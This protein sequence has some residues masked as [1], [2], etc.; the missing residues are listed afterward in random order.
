MT[1]LVGL[2]LGADEPTRTVDA[3]GLVF[4]APA[5]WKPVTVTNPMRKAQLK[6]EPAKGDERG[7]ELIVSTFAGTA[8]G[9]DAN[10]GRWE[11]T[12][13]DKDGNPVKAEVKKVKGKNVDVTRVELAGHYYPA[14]FGGP[15][16]PD[17]PNTR[18]LGAIV[19]TD[20]T[21]YFVRFIGPE[22]TISDAKADFDK[23]I[24]SMKAEGK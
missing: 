23:L 15:Q 14:N 1:A 6:I 12:F 10:V 7:A 17:Q 21:S 19:L 18:L 20:D 8:G 9:V 24:A 16:Q 4:T 5:A 13:K 11:K 22:K 2:S 3:G